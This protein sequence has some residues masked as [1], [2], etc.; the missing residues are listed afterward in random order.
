MKTGLRVRQ[1]SLT[2]DNPKNRQTSRPCG[3]RERAFDEKPCENALAIEPKKRGHTIEQQRRFDVFYEGILVD[4][5][6]PNPARAAR[7][8][9]HR[10]SVQGVVHKQHDSLAFPKSRIGG[11]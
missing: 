11:G 1:G 2:T 8:N 6:V 9:A 7:E 10:E 3:G 5:L 4:P